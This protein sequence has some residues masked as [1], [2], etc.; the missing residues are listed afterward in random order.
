MIIQAINKKYQSAINKAY[1]HYRTYHEYVNLDGTF[2][3]DKE[4]NANDRKQATQFDKYYNIY[5][6]LPKREQHNF[7]RQHKNIHGY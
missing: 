2:E 3:T 7:D 4:Q 6:E 1:Q 5:E